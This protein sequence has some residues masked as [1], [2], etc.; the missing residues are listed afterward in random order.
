[1]LR[2][3]KKISPYLT[4]WLLFEKVVPLHTPLQLNEGYPVVLLFDINS[5]K[6]LKKSCLIRSRLASR[7]QFKKKK[8]QCVKELFTLVKEINIGILF[9]SVSV[10]S[11]DLCHMPS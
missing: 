4:V 10:S 7:C 9:C 8:K 6:I 5:K 1:M 3:Q 11:V 2:K